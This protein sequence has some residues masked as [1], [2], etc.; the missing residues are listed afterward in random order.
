MKFT[1]KLHSAI[2]I[3]RTVLCVGLDPLPERIPAAIRVQTDSVGEQLAI[4]CRVVVD[5]TKDL[6]AAYKPNLAFFEALGVSGME[7]FQAVLE[8]LPEDKIV[9]ADAKRGDIGN[10]AQQYRKAYMETWPC[11]AIT[12]SPLMGVE[13][14]TPFLTQDRFGIYVLTLTSNPGAADFLDQRLENG[15]TLS[16]HIAQKIGHLND[17]FPGQ[18]GMVI[19][20]TQTEKLAGIL[21]LNP[22]GALLIPGIGVQG[23]KI[24][25]LRAALEQHKG[26]P[27]IN[28]SR[29]IMYGHRTSETLTDM[30]EVKALIRE[31]ALTY[32]NEMKPITDLFLDEGNV[33]Q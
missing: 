4:F 25:E 19:G 24:E 28:V 3:N 8:Y 18:A 11:D 33:E 9:I 2:Q 5:A 1:E 32:R 17:K 27:L 7:A 30:G 14:L 29:S 20:A 10:T 31:R 6:C 23:G 21:K 12:L 22:N 16:Q 13:T 15:Q 26:L